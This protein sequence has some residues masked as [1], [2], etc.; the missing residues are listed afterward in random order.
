MFFFF[1]MI[2]RPPRSTLSSSSAAS[3]VYK[4]QVR[5]RFHLTMSNCSAGSKA[6][7]TKSSALSRRLRVVS[8][9]SQSTAD[10]ERTTKIHAL[11]AGHCNS[12]SYFQRESARNPN[13]EQI[14]TAV[15]QEVRAYGNSPK[16][17]PTHSPTASDSTKLI[18]VSMPKAQPTS[19]EEDAVYRM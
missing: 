12:E 2:R 5:G 15:K 11:I 17:S 18:D 8:K 14:R 13:F 19:P 16:I 3:D 4:R 9:K 7:K 10:K 6:K 1:L